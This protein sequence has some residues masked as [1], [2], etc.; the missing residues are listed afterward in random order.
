MLF[1]KQEMKLTRGVGM[2]LLSFVFFLFPSNSDGFSRNFSLFKLR[3]FVFF[4]YHCICRLS[5]YTD[6]RGR[7]DVRFIGLVD[8]EVLSHL[9]VG[10]LGRTIERTGC[11]SQAPLDTRDA[12]K[13]FYGCL[14]FIS[15][16]FFVCIFF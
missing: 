10:F 13:D 7:Q 12:I 3:R 4:Q 14:V 16:Q 2:T 6:L 8:I 11:L 1:L 9:P 5:F 15:K